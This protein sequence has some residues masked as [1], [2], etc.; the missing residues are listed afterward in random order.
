[1]PKQE[2]VIVRT[3]YGEARFYKNADGTKSKI[4]LKKSKPSSPLGVESRPVLFG[5]KS[6]RPQKFETLLD[7]EDEPTAKGVD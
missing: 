4:L 5:A 2:L 3:P 1:M 6:T 7:D